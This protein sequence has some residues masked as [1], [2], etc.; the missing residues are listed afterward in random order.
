MITDKELLRVAQTSVTF[1]MGQDITPQEI[2]ELGE[3]IVEELNSL[4]RPELRAFLCGLHASLETLELIYEKAPCMHINVA[5][6]SLSAEFV[7]AYDLYDRI[8]REG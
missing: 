4:S 3:E 7:S 5:I 6:L 8:L 2:E 1:L